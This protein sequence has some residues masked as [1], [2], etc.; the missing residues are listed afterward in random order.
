MCGFNL[1]VVDSGAIGLDGNRTALWSGQ[2]SRATNQA[3][4]Q[5]SGKCAEG[6]VCVSD[7]TRTVAPDDN[8]ALRLQQTTRAFFSFAHFPETIREIFNS[9]FQ[10]VPDRRSAALHDEEYHQHADEDSAGS[11]SIHD[12]IE[13]RALHGSSVTGA[14]DECADCPRSWAI[15]RSERCKFIRD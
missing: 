14:P 5:L 2:L 6:I 8:I 7:L 9:R 1:F 10:F 3:F 11:D 13:S 15:W 4:A 12:D